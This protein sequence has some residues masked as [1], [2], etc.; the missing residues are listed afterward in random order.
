MRP[1]RAS[2]RAKARPAVRN[3]ALSVRH[4]TAPVIFGTLS[5]HSFPKINTAVGAGLGREA[6]EVED[7]VYLLT[8]AVVRPLV[9]H[10]EDRQHA[11]PTARPTTLIA[12]YP[13]W[14]RRPRNAILR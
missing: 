8:E 10:E 11:M 13:R 3:R 1:E 14:R 2:G 7:A 6:V 9:A 5:M 12:V 4:R